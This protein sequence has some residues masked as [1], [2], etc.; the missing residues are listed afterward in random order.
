MTRKEELTRR[1]D[2]AEKLLRQHVDPPRPLRYQCANHLADALGSLS[3]CLLESADR[4]LDAAE[5]AAA[6][7]EPDVIKRPRTFTLPDLLAI[8]RDQRA[9]LPADAGHPRDGCPHRGA[10]L[11]SV[12]RKPAI[13]LDRRGRRAASQSKG[14]AASIAPE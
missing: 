5:K 9:S 10:S 3:K 2:R 12:V 14:S 1:L 6:E 11:H 7:T 4:A 13:P 8:I